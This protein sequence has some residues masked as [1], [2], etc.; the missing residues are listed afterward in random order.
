MREF[1]LLTFKMHVM[2]ITARVTAA[3]IFSIT[4][5]YQKSAESIW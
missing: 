1:N 4:G 2:P 3:L 5:C